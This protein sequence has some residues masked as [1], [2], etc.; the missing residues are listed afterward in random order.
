MPFPISLNQQEYESLI[1][2]A[3]EGAKDDAGNVDQNKAVQID[4]WL[5]LIEK[6]NGI[7]RDAVWIQWQESDSPL[8]PTTN[9]PDVWPPELRFYL[10][11]TTRL[12]S[13]AD[14]DAVI[15][16]KTSKPANILVTRDPGGRVGF[17]PLEDFNFA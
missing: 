5:R 16:E 15:E 8:P 1:A 17:T 2:L 13:R 4:S 12:V 14:V 7:T 6:K 11:L 3:R 9:F 10:E